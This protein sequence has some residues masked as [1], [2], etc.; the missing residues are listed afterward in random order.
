MN[1]FMDRWRSG[2]LIS[3]N[4]VRG[5]GPTMGLAIMETETSMDKPVGAWHDPLTFCM[6]VWLLMS[7][8]FLGF[9]SA[10]HAESLVAWIAAL[11]LFLSA[12]NVLI[13]PGV[14]DEYLDAAV[15]VGLIVSPWALGYA[16]D[17]PATLNAV[18]VGI[19]VL[20]CAA[21]ALG[22]D[23]NWHWHLPGGHGP[24]H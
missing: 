13:L 10:T 17:F 11:L 7:P 16:Q 8:F 2:P 23:R 21:L 3:I 14:L 24:A 4:G 20:A 12:N 6:A 1:S 15:G 19:V 18:A 22:R 5:A 9:A